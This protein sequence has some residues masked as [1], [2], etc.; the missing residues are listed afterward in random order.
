MSAS[1]SDSAGNAVDLRVFAE[2]DRDFTEED[3]GILANVGAS[4]QWEFTW[5]SETEFEGQILVDLSCAGSSC[6]DIAP[7]YLV[8]EFPCNPRAAIT[9]VKL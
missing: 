5:I 1:F 9:G 2:Y 8:A 7:D 6:V 4:R 3:M